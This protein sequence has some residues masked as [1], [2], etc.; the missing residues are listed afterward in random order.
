[1]NST[2]KERKMEARIVGDEVRHDTVSLYGGSAETGKF[3]ITLDN[4]SAS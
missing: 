4:T 1:M 3:R 2:E